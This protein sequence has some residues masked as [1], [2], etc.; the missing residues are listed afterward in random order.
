MD[1]KR[2][3]T[4]PMRMTST[5]VP[6]WELGLSLL[7]LLLAGISTVLLVARLFRVRT[8]LRG[9]SLSIRRAWSAL[10]G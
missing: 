5:A 3:P 4:P 1:P 6:T 8:L 2:T 7:F 9:E 10:T